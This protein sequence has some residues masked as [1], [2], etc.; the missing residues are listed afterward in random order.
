MADAMRSAEAA[1]RLRAWL[2][3]STLYETNDDRWPLI[4]DGLDAAVAAAVSVT[5]ARAVALRDAAAELVRVCR[6]PR[7]QHA[8][9]DW[10]AG[11]N[12]RLAARARVREMLADHWLVAA[13]AMDDAA[14]R[15]A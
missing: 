8:T 5:E 9:A 2:T 11:L 6:M 7:A 3:A 15:A 1:K 13:A 12:L 4:L 10:Y 14:A